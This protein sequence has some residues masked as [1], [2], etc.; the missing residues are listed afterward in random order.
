MAG[1]DRSELNEVLAFVQRQAEDYL[2]SLDER[3]VRAPGAD[4]AADSFDEP[5]PETGDGALK[6]LSLLQDQGL[7][8]AVHSSG[9]RFFHFV[10]GGTTPAAMGADMFG[11]VVD[12]NPGMWLGSPLGGKL[13]TLSIR[14]LLDLFRLPASWG[15]VLTTGATMANYVGLAAARRWWADRHGIDVDEQ[16]LASLPQIPLL[17]SGYIHASSIKTSAMLG[18]GRANV[19]RFERDD[20]G[21]LD[22]E[23]LEKALL[24]LDGAPAIIVANA[25]EV[26]AGDFDPIDQMAELAERYECWLHV[27]GAFGLFARL[28]D[29]TSHLA[30]GI[31]RADS[32]TADG[33]KWLNIPYDC[34]FAFLK[35]PTLL[36]GV[37]GLSAAYLTSRGERPNVGFVSPESSQRARGLTVWATLKAYGRD[38]YRE[39]IERGLDLAQHIGHLVDEA[40]DLERLADV[41]LNIVCFRF[42][43]GGLSE[44]Q[45]NELNTK[46]G[47]AMLDDG[48]VYVGTTTYGGRIAFRPALV[49]W[50]TSEADV[51]LLIDV[52]RELG[53][54]LRAE[55]DG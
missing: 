45:L 53:A 30:R 33:H 13:E 16:G 51:E 2:T 17:S 48:R 47:N 49:N 4:E 40:P 25:G 8:A 24:Q 9:P 35:N 32:V 26:N 27:D 12:Q 1:P 15:G 34:G 28:S 50:R 7:E 22:L 18:I 10:I 44:E 20:V 6:A 36:Q 38:G 14:W 3:A 54:G 11:S 39:I 5:L 55:L 19:Q 42:N 23:A 21:R 29:K 41:Q 43:P 46:L 52:L 31:E 37:F